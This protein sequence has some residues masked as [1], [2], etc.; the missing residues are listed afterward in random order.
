MNNKIISKICAF[1]SLL[2]ILLFFS[3]YLHADNNKKQLTLYFLYKS[4]CI[5]CIKIDKELNS[6]NKRCPY[7]KIIKLDVFNIDNLE[8]IALLLEKCQVPDNLGFLTPTI[9]INDKYYIKNDINIQN[10]EL[11]I[12]NLFYKKNHHQNFTQNRS[13][14]PV[15]KQTTL[16]DK[17]HSFTFWA[18]LTSG[19]VDGI[20]PCAFAVLIFFLSY[21]KIAGRN[22]LQLVKI[23]TI[24][25]LTVFITYLLIGFGFFQG[26][27]LLIDKHPSISF[28]FYIFSGVLALLFSLLSIWDIYFLKIGKKNKVILQ[29]NNKNK[30]LVQH[31]IR[32]YSRG[33]SIIIGTLLIGISVSFLELG[34]TGQIYLPVITFILQKKICFIRAFLM[35]VL[36]NFAFIL[37]LLFIF[38]LSV[39]GMTHIRLLRWFQNNLIKLKLVTAIIFLILAVLIFVNAYT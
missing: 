19:L 8:K 28:Y 35:L 38:I 12:N 14:K 5:K 39:F 29:L 33:I 6:L 37:P 27:K 20:N 4:G 11:T 7:L 1:F 31:V 18:V 32:T 15:L 16:F 9:L 2:L 21:L 24:Y 23:G 10:L 34:C 30:N 36:Y 17:F 22:K 25:T 3:L 26:L 13:L